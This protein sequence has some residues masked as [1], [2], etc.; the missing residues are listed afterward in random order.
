ML[1][2]NTDIHMVENRLMYFKSN[3]YEVTDWILF[4]LFDSL[5]L[6]I[7]VN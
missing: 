3:F 5:T 1:I 6:K 2:L 7:D 4:V